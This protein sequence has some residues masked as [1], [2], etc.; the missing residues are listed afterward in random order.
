MAT[1]FS[2]N[3]KVEIKKISE[4][5]GG[6]YLALVPS[7]PG[8]MS[9]GET[10]EEAL[11]NVRDAIFSWIET[12]KELG[13]EIPESDEYKADDEY[14]GK[15][16]LRIPKFV[17]KQLAVRAKEEDCSINQL[18][19]TYIAL[20]LGK[21]FGTKNISINIDNGSEVLRSALNKA[22]RNEW[23]TI[24]QSKDRTER[25]FEMITNKNNN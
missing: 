17:H 6:G 18:I 8:C 2:L 11:E 12:A 20:G 10:P 23:K 15:L 19:Q 9:D 22:M 13:R 4:D 14:S 1:D 5:D 21:D 24:T 16:S 25:I 3:Y 7:L